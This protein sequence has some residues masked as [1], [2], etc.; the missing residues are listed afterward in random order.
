MK[1]LFKQEY[2]PV[3]VEIMPPFN[4]MKFGKVYISEKYNTST[5]K[6]LCGCGERV[7]LP[8][9]HGNSNYGW[10]MVKEPNGSVS[11]TPSVGNYQQACNTHYIMTKNVANF[12]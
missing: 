8:I 6:C 10:D 1:T 11:F 4:E 9:N 3:F 7:V 2:Q 12:V 5:H